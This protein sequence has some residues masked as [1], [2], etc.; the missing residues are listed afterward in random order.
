MSLP[1]VT[2][3]SPEQIA[4]A[5]LPGHWSFGYADK[6]RFNELDLLNHVNN[7]S[8]LAW[9]ETVRVRFVR[10]RGLIHGREDVP[11]IVIRAQSIEYLSPVLAETTYIMATRA[12]AYRRTSFTLEYM[13]FAENEV[14]ATGSSVVV[15]LHSD[16][17]G[18]CPLPDDLVSSF[19]EIDKATKA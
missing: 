18:K 10:S 13:C 4:Q 9:F 3:L 14:K 12:T 8:Y 2:P 7:L 15:T 6:V 19:Q 1:F 16:G 11:Q 5:G 17:S